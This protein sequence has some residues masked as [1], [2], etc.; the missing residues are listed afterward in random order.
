MK[1][2][3]MIEYIALSHFPHIKKGQ[4]KLSDVEFKRQIGRQRIALNPT[5]SKEA[6]FEWMVDF[7]FR[8]RD[9][10]VNFV[11]INLTQILFRLGNVPLMEPPSEEFQEIP[12]YEWA[13]APVYPDFEF[14]EVRTKGKV[15]T[16]LVLDLSPYTVAD[17]KR[18]E[19]DQW[20][21]LFNE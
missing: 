12:F 8:F 5:V 17:L 4:L 6:L 14:Q 9:N 10:S 11:I 15:K 13:G 7:A 21:F 20:C 19:T 2:K 16:R 3:K 18:L 1:W